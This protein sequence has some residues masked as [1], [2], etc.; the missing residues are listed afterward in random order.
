LEATRRIRAAFPEARI[1][2]VTQH[3]DPHW[4]RAAAQAGACGDALQ[5]N[6]LERRQ[7]LQGPSGTEHTNTQHLPQAEKGRKQ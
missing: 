5:E 7:R 4:R 3:D 2:I 1:I 6:R